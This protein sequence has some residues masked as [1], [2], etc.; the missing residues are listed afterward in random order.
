MKNQPIFFMQLFQNL[1]EKFCDML[2][3]NFKRE[4]QAKIFLMSEENDEKKYN[5]IYGNVCDEFFNI[6]EYGKNNI[7][8]FNGQRTARSICESAEK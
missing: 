3:R 4:V 2:N 8:E 5:K 1:R 6:R 7:S